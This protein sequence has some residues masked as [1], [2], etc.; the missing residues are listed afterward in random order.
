MPQLPQRSFHR[1]TRQSHALAIIALMTMMLGSLPAQEDARVS[2]GGDHWVLAPQPDVADPGERLSTPGYAASGWIRARVPGTVYGSYILAG[3][4]PE[5]AFGDRAYR[6]DFAKYDRN[7][8]YRTEFTVPPQ[9]GDGRVWLNLDGV[10]RDADVYLNGRHIGGMK[11]FFQRGRFDVTTIL[12]RQGANAL[13]VL[14]YVP[15]LAN[16]RS[17]RPGTPK[18]GDLENSSSP[19]FICTRGWDWMPPV[20]GFDMG[21]YKDVSLTTT[22]AVSLIDPWI[23]TDLP[24]VD[25]A[26][27]SIQA[28]VANSASEEV[29][30]EIR[31]EIEP[32]Q[33]SVVQPLTLH[34]GETRTIHLTAADLPAL[35]IAHPRLWWPNG[36][37]EANL[38]TC[39]LEFR[40]ASGVSDQKTLT[41]GIKHYSYDTAHDTLHLYIN[42]VKLF[43]KGGSWGM[44]EWLLRCTA[45]DYDT[46]VRFHKEENFN[47]IRNWMGM[48]PDQAFYDACDQYGIMVWDELWLNNGSGSLPTDL[49]VYKANVVEKIKQ[50]R[51]HPCIAL[52]CAMNE[53]TPAP[54]LNTALAGFISTYDG[55]DRAY[56]ANSR[57]GA[58]SGS[59]PWSARDPRTYFTG[60]P[61]GGGNKSPFGMRSEL[62]T[63]TVPTYDTLKRCLP[64]DKMWPINDLWKMHFFGGWASGAGPGGYSQAID[65]RYGRATSVEDYCRKAQLLNIETLKAMFE[66]WVDHS[67]TTA[68]G[69]IIWMSQSA[70]PS[71]V[72]QTYD[73][74]YD[75]TGAFWGSKTACEPVH[76]YWN[77][78]NDH[79]RVANTSGA[80]V[81]GLTADAWIYDLDGSQKAHQ[82]RHIDSPLGVVADCFTLAFP[83]GLTPTH[84]IRLRLTSAAG[85]TV[86]DNFYWRGTTALNYTAL[87]A[88]KPVQLTE[89]SR[90][91]RVGSSSIMTA[92]ITNPGQSGTV[93]L[94]IRPK[95]VRADSGEQILPVHAS[96]GY[97]SLLPG[98]SKEVTLEFSPE[99]AGSQPAR[100]V[101]ECY[102]DPP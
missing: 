101:V 65:R 37:G 61:T 25:D 80:A 69:L 92:T 45:R 72:W 74:Y 42:G 17:V 6:V 75:L 67:D 11:G 33:I 14:A 79:I 54:E 48:T 85:Q 31:G 3:L 46:K 99:S 64:A 27:I 98:E 87:A 19:S 82:T 78:T 1:T 90:I 16:P 96:D 91:E 9:Y 41:F 76:I 15:V 60:V 38:Y 88:L 100:L 36:Y 93:A 56:Q 24:T 94:A 26:R 63:A 32:G 39:H 30:G 62:G 22:G 8:W 51:N 59:G 20:P 70:Y 21:I 58:L 29:T 89:A 44:A 13:A 40:T 81:Q 55:N 102:N 57:S 23:R 49:G 68:A 97:F 73:Y 50:M 86:S 53:G 18:R 35:R 10:N 7:F 66:G 77:P 84:F 47:I 4:E 43:P 5:P 52:W 2:L 83:A 34:P 95:L 12:H 28:D 71:L